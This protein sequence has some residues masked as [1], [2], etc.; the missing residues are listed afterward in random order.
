MSVNGN[1]LRFQFRFPS[2]YTLL[3]QRQYTDVYHLQSKN[4]KNSNSTRTIFSLKKKTE[5]SKRGE[6][7]HWRL[8]PKL[9]WTKAV[10][11]CS[12]SSIFLSIITIWSNPACSVVSQQLNDLTFVKC[13]TCN[14]W[15][16]T[17]ENSLS[18]W[19]NDEADETL[20][21]TAL[22]TRRPMAME[23]GRH[24][25]QGSCIPKALCSSL[26]QCVMKQ[27]SAECDEAG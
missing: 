15:H 6:E 22:C 24:D 7:T 8:I 10:P 20:N 21:A 25:G 12:S 26:A 4:I 11:S 9:E 5:I 14:D 16:G 13:S 19:R 17:I 3:A 2:S 23:R 1:L 27:V 18:L